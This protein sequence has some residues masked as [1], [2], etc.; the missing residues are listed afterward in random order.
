MRYILAKK[1]KKKPSPS[2]RRRVVSPRS[3]KCTGSS[4]FKA[5]EAC[6]QAVLTEPALTENFTQG[7]QPNYGSK[8]R[9]QRKLATR[10]QE[11]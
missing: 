10:K 8:L 6:R 11:K 4:L 7:L 1:K 2:G 5:K 9:K 3:S